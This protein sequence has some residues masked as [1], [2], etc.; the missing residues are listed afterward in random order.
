MAYLRRYPID[1]LKLDNS[2]T[3][4]LLSQTDTRVIA[5]A[6]IALA[7][8]LGISIVAEGVEHQTQLETLADL[9]VIWVQGFLLSPA[10][11]VDQILGGGL[12]NLG[13]RLRQIP[14]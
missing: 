11:P 8:R 14:G 9:G 5:E 3:R 2:Y 1:G 6:I 12:G 4:A 13:T 7:H 10:V